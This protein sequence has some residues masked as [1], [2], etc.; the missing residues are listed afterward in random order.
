[1]KNLGLDFDAAFD[2][3]GDETILFSFFQ[4]SRHARQIVRRRYNNS[5]FYDDLGDLIAASLEIF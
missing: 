3:V 4:D 1:M 5:R 2:R